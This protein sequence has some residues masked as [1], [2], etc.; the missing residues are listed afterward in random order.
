MSEEKNLE[1]K[2]GRD[3]RSLVKESNEQQRVHIHDRRAR[4]R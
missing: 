2:M 1:R 3:L 4:V